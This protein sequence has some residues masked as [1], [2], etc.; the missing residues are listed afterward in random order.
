MKT[1]LSIAALFFATAT[2]SQVITEPRT[3]GD[4][5]GVRVS[6]AI[7]VEITQGENCTVEIVGTANE[8]KEVKTELN[9]GV[10]SISGKAPDD[11]D[12]KVKIAVKNLRMLDM[13]GA[14]SI[15]STNQISADN[16]QITG[17]GAAEVKLDVNAK[18]IKTNLSG[19]STVKLSGTTDTLDALGSGASE[20]KYYS[21]SANKVVVT[22]GGAGTAHVTANNSITATANGAS[23]IH[24]QGNAAE[25]IINASGSASVANRDGQDNSNDTTS[26]H[27]GKYDVS[28]MENDDERSK[29]EKKAD[30]EDYNFWE[31][32]DFG[33]AGYTTFDNQVNLP[34]SMKFLELNYAK[35]YE[36][37]WNAFQKNIHIYRNNVNLGTGIGLTWYHYDFR[38]SYSLTP[39]V[40]YATAVYDSLNYRH[41]R[42]SMCY[43]NVPLFLE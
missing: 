28:V 20:L 12:F 16:L 41:N 37:G 15:V 24:Y 14:S 26:I 36:F 32:A 23:E 11:E 4:F 39:H 9:D 29:R 22:A 40:D 43:L 34:S 25:K 7:P 30:N 35:S 33:V 17:S 19:A 38:N 27:F 8:I 6:S 10:L 21:L 31:G 13:S 3:L 18:S 1:I 2:F 5:T 42:L